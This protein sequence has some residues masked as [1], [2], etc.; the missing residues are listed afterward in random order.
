MFS[1]M[2]SIV[3]KACNCFQLHDH[4]YSN[5]LERVFGAVQAGGYFSLC[6]CLTTWWL[7]IAELVFDVTGKVSVLCLTLSSSHVHFLHVH[8]LL[9]NLV[10]LWLCCCIVITFLHCSFLVGSH[11]TPLI[12]VRHVSHFTDRRCVADLCVVDA[13]LYSCLLVSLGF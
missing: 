7:A 3:Y 11:R 1:T 2:Y 12:P 13:A 8:L 9:P 10:Q 6:V 4:L 5:A